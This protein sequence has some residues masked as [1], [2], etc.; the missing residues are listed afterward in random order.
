MVGL[1][2]HLHLQAA[3]RERG[4]TALVAQSFRAPYHL[5]KP[6]W[7][8]ASGVLLVQVVNP[9]AGLLAG[10][11]VT[12]EISVAAGAALLVTT[13]SA[14]RIFRMVEGTAECRQQFNVAAGAWLEVM[15]E[16]LVPHR[17]SSYRQTTIVHVE[18]GGGLFFVDQVMPGRV[19]HGEAWSWRS[20]CLGLECRLN[21]ELLVRERLNQSGEELKGLAAFGG[22]GP[23]ACVANALLI[24]GDGKASNWRPAIESLH[25]A[26][27]WVGVSAL[28]RGGWS[29][30]V[31]ARDGAEMRA[32][33]QQLRTILAECFPKL[34]CD[35]RKL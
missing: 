7:D 34:R 33:L 30:K 9:T 32:L 4:R 1:A 6:Y 29:I 19:A 25:G 23:G 31:I 24:A 28:R 18:S 22:S 20:L 3:P 15:P 14:S 26:G 17:D 13:P 27:R 16:P 2:G 8:E 11:R 5:S 10:D 12:A 35:P 21:G